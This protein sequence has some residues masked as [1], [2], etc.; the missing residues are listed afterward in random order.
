MGSQGLVGR[1][2]RCAARV[3]GGER[4]GSGPVSGTS[5]RRRRGALVLVVGTVLVGVLVGCAP[6]EPVVESPSPVVSGEQ[7]PTPV[8]TPT[9]TGPVKPERPA[10]MDRTD[11]VGAAAA[12]TYFLELYPYV[13]GTGDLEEW[14]ALSFPEECEFCVNLAKS[15]TDLRSTGQTFVGG[16]VEA[17]VSKAYEFDTLYGAYPLDVAVRQA[18]LQ[19]L[20]KDGNVVSAEPESSTTL[21][22]VVI[23][24]GTAWRLMDVGETSAS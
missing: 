15:A 8:P 10:D 19:I 6:T 14:N 12:A 24:D 3:V 5:A 4:P 16:G 13:K 23:H 20:A 17:E 9:P 2:R 7:S 18:E 21:R 22:V 11:G 1:G